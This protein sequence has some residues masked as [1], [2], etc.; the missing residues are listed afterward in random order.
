MTTAAPQPLALAILLA[1]RDAGAIEQ[2]GRRMS[3]PRLAKL[4]GLSASAVLRALAALGDAS[5]AGQ[6]GP[7]WVTVEL[8]EGRWAICLTDVGEAALLAQAALERHP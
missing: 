8:T 7:G 2:A 5:V 1:L 6:S 3:L 4:L